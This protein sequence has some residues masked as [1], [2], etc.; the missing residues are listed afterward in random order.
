MTVCS[1]CEAPAAGIVPVLEAVGGAV[2]AVRAA[3]PVG[4]NTNIVQP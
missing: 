4:R 3:Y 2:D 1:W